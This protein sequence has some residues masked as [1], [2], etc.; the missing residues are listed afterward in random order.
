MIRFGN[1]TELVLEQ[2]EN[3]YQIIALILNLH[4]D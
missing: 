4:S 1:I 2:R 3:T